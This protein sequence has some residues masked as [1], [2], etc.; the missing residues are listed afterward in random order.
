[1]KAKTKK[2]LKELVKKS[3][4]GKIIYP[5]GLEDAI[6]GV[7]EKSGRAIM[8]ER[9]CVEILTK[10]MNEEDALDYFFY[11]VKGSYIGK[12][13]PIWKEKLI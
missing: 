1:M 7:S 2:F 9:K 3:P 5:T 11:N 12:M 4:S 6:I 13:T 8:S 10:E